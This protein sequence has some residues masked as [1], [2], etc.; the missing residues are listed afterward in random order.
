MFSDSYLASTN[1]SLGVMR[2]NCQSGR[3]KINDKI[4]RH[5]N[6]V[7]RM[8]SLKA[9]PWIA[10]MSFASARSICLRSSMSAWY[11]TGPR[12]RHKPEKT[13]DELYIL[14]HNNMLLSKDAG[15]AHADT[16][17][18]SRQSSLSFFGGGGC[19]FFK[20]EAEMRV[21]VAHR[22]TF[23][24]RRW[25]VS[26]SETP[27]STPGERNDNNWQ[28]KNQ[29]TQKHLSFRCCHTANSWDDW[30]KWWCCHSYCGMRLC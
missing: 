11:R 20:T 3:T 1:G 7:I 6:G 29:G 17:T 8:S 28:Q 16:C 22:L 4:K 23:R 30:E 5:D 26:D 14:H 12:V 18:Y 13:K 27:G 15:R 2:P 10:N 21:L 24:G 9:L 19:L 25:Q